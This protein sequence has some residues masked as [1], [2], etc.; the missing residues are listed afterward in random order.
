MASPAFHQLTVASVRPLTSDSVAIAFTVP[1][2]L[3]PAYAFIPGQYLTLR[4]ELDGEDIR[5]SYSISSHRE[6]LLEVGIKRVEGGLFSTYAQELKAGDRLQ[7]MTPQGRFTAPVGET[8]R[9][10][11]VAA[12][13]GITPCL[14][15]ARS[16]LMDESDS[17]VCLLYGNRTTASVMFR[18]DIHGLK[19]EHIDRFMLMHVMSGERQDAECLNGRIDGEKLQ[20]LCQQGLIDVTTFDDIYLCGPQEMIDSATEVLLIAG[21]NKQHI[22]F[23]LFTTVLG[24]GEKQNATQKQK[25][26]SV[27]VE[28]GASVTIVHDGAERDIR[29]DATTETVLAA[30]QRAGLD[31]P[32]SC[33]GGMCATCRCKVV[34]G[35]TA[36]D[37]NFSLADWEVEAGFT[38]ACQTRPV[39]EAVV[40]DFDAF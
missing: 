39:S 20:R 5:R 26:Q 12:G 32:F 30:A 34:S 29:V 31:L 10:L 27:V 8:K 40:L 3:A 38:L 4:T 23:E 19:D 13:S 17:E 16:V 21:V 28:G 11:L 14:S 25:I 7:V 22:H 24:G 2:E 37:L 18:D 1:D 9:Y 36:M 33:A 15:I 6:S 35:E